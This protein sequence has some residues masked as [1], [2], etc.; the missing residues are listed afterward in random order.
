MRFL[1]K[2]RLFR[3]VR[4]MVYGV[5]LLSLGGFLYTPTNALYK[6]YFLEVPN[7]T[8]KYGEDTYVV[9][10]G[11]SDGI[12]REFCHALAE[13]GFNIILIARNK[14]KLKTV[15]E[16]LQV[17]YGVKTTSY[18]IDFEQAREREYLELSKF[19]KGF[20]VSILVN[21]VGIPIRKYI[22]DYTYN[23]AHTVF[24]INCQSIINMSHILYPQFFARQR[25]S[26]IINVSSNAATVPFPYLGVYSS[27]KAFFSYYSNIMSIELSDRIDVMVLEPGLSPPRGSELIGK[28]IQASSKD[29]VVKGALKD[30]GRTSIS[31]G[32]PRHM[33]VNWALRWTPRYIREKYLKYSLNKEFTSRGLLKGPELA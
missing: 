32:S 7:L 23:D 29:E 3:G 13:Q 2:F 8:R 17:R 18:V 26:A 19:L 1:P 16:E 31:Y 15:E 10:T 4:R 20:E 9:V 11:A 30:L 6:H 27:S 33:M 14:H 21:N 28:N 25:K 22:Q 12:G 5:G 24:Q